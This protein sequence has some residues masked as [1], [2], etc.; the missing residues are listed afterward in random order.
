M[1]ADEPQTDREWIM[2]IDGKVDQLSTDLKAFIKDT[3]D[4]R[5]NCDH[6]LETLETF[7][8]DHE[9]QIK[10]T[11]RS[12]AIIAGAISTIGVLFGI[13]ISIWPWGRA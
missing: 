7:R 6:R 13:L 8:T 5:G 11:N 4:R 2:R 1:S 9:A 10:A 3:K 12:A